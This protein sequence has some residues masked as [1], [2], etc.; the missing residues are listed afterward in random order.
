MTITG[1]SPNST[2]QVC[3]QL[4]VFPS[5]SVQVRARAPSGLRIVP[6]D[7]VHQNVRVS[8]AALAVH[9][10]TPSDTSHPSTVV[11][12]NQRRTEPMACPAKVEDA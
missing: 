4:V 7:D 2:S 11:P 5:A 9:F 6:P 3:L 12:S 10:H 1:V 8:T